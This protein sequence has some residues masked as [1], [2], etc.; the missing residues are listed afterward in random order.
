MRLTQRTQEADAAQSALVQ[1][2][3][4]GQQQQVAL[5]QAQQQGD[6]QQAALA[7][8]DAKLRSVQDELIDPAL[9]HLKFGASPA[10]RI[11]A[12]N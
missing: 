2:K 11:H 5:A 3:A 7:L 12:S 10:Y 6:Q 8:S 4:Q 1:A 9:S